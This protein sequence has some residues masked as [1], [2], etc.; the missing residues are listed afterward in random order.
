MSK[1]VK[2]VAIFIWFIALIILYIIP[3]FN[4]IIYWWV[5]FGGIFL[6]WQFKLRSATFFIFAFLL[7]IPAAFIAAVSPNIF[8]EDLMRIS[9]IFFIIG[10][11]LA[12]FAYKKLQ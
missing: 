6:A 9:F 5:L 7:F 4:T 3:T 2:V 11:I 10:Y 12:L 1:Q 8:A